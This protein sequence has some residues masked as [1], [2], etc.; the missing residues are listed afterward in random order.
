MTSLRTAVWDFALAVYPANKASLLHWQVKGAGVNDLLLCG[1]AL[2]HRKY[3]DW[4][5]WLAVDRGRP[6]T[7]LRRLRHYR[8]QLPA[9]HPNRA[10]ALQWELVLEQWDLAL[11]ADC[12]TD[13]P[14]YLSVAEA[15]AALGQDWQ[16]TKTQLLHSLVQQ[17]GQ[18]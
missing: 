16:I 15:I 10:P 4:S 5:G 8:L 1:F 18:S 12:L 9:D 13:Q 3:L 17:L 7:V 6:R 14:T 2:K 11:L